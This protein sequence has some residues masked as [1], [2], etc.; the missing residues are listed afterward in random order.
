MRDEDDLS[1][2]LLTDV[3]VAGD[4]PAAA[5][6][7]VVPES[8]MATQYDVWRSGRSSLAD[9]ASRT[10]PA[11]PDDAS[12]AQAFAGG[13]TPDDDDHFSELMYA[14]I[15]E[16]TEVLVPGDPDRACPPLWASLMHA[17]AVLPPQPR[18][19][20]GQGQPAGQPSAAD[21]ALPPPG[22]A[23]DVPEAVPAADADPALAG[24]VPELLSPGGEALDEAPP[25]AML[26]S[27]PE[28]R[29]L[30]PVA[31]PN[32][33][34]QSA[35]DAPPGP[36]DVW[37][38]AHGAL[39]DTPGDIAPATGALPVAVPGGPSQPLLLSAP[40]GP[41][42]PGGQGAA[43]QAPAPAL[44]AFAPT[45]HS[46]A[47]RPDDLYAAVPPAADASAIAGNEAPR[48]A[49]RPPSNPAQVREPRRPDAMLRGN[50]AGA[51]AT[52]GGGGDINSEGVA[53]RLR[54][55]LATYLT[56]EGRAM[57][58]AHCRDAL[59]DHTSWLVHQVT[60]ELALVLE[61]EM[62]NWVRDAMRNMPP[63]RT[64]D[65]GRGQEGD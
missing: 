29:P 38:S 9:A 48:A 24:V 1:I 23:M 54:G 35:G 7:P 25:E 56:G 27:L 5:N 20:Q 61:A 43:P 19:P 41:G 6:M 13:E 51:S 64:G 60:R 11:V 4:A 37:A 46:A 44:Q 50:L 55:R 42:A 17:R 18:S 52:G 21:Q 53:D 16:L 36:S 8:R 34:A 58:E 49:P 65:D 40:S 39:P 12:Y 59:A 28:E 33:E 62:S 30:L 26:V 10:D 31:A 57:V 22:P 3:L 14:N 47:D 2:P 63:P 45:A 32:G 15:P